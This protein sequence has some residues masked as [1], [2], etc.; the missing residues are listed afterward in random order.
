MTAR[1]KASPAFFVHGVIPDGHVITRWGQG[2]SY[3]GETV[4]GRFNGAGILTTDASDRFDGVMDR[5]QDERLRRAAARQW[6]A[7]CRRLERRPAQRQGRAAPCRRHRGDRRTFV[8]GKLSTAAAPTKSRRRSAPD[9]EMPP[10]S[11]SQESAPG[12]ANVPFGGVS[13]KTLIG[14]DGS[15]IALTLI[16][17]GME[18]QV[19]P[20][21]GT[22]TQDHLHLHDRPHGH[23]GGRQRQ[24]QHRIQ[25]SPASSA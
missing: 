3:D 8:D 25:S 12:I 18:L 19:V 2:W 24:P 21:G 16:E 6:R 13:G 1:P 14:V 11:S 5:R 9:S 23:G 20:A 15:S 22:A 10:D 17:G 7:L 4:D